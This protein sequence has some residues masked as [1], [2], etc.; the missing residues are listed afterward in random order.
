MI[1][2][3]GDE[4]RRDRS[5][6]Y[7]CLV[8]GLRRTARAQRQSIASIRH[9]R[10][11]CRTARRGLQSGRTDQGQ[12]ARAVAATR[13]LEDDRGGEFTTAASKSPGNSASR[14]AI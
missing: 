4:A 12:S 9:L 3:N 1:G 7:R 8:T 6:L 10:C 2:F 13:W 14:P 5:I 11:R